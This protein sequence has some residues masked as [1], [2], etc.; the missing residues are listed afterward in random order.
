M[1][2]R[3]INNQ[4]WKGAK[5]RYELHVGEHVAFVEYF[6]IKNEKAY[7]VYTEVPKELSGKKIGFELVEMVLKDLEKQHLKVVPIYPFVV[8]YIKRHKEYTALVPEE[9]KYLIQ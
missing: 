1:E 2:H 8:L 3:F 7:L 6:L 4:E 9:F 5:K